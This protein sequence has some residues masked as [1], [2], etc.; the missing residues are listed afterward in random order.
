MPPGGEGASPSLQP[1]QI[2]P[3][4]AVAYALEVGLEAL[5]GEFYGVGV[6][7]G[8]EGDGRGGAEAAV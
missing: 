1:L 3:T 4:I 2:Q 8:V 6:V 5:L 7:V